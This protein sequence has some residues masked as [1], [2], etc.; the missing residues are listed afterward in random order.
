[1]SYSPSDSDQ[2]HLGPERGENALIRSRF[3]L[4][5]VREFFATAASPAF[6]SRARRPF[7]S[8]PGRQ[9]LLLKEGRLAQTTEIG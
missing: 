9:S 2:W 1:M 4:S 6:V 3:P 8:P 7:V 5:P